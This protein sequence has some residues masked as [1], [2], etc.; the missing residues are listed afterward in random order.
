[1][2]SLEKIKDLDDLAREL[3]TLRDSKRIV[4]CHGVFDLLHIGHIRYF[5]QARKMGDVLVVTVTPDRYVNKGPHRPAFTETLRVE[6]I[7]ALDVVDYVTVNRWATAVEAIELLRPH[8]YV[9]GSEYRDAADDISGKIVDEAN[10]IRAVGGEMAFSDDL[11]FSS[12]S[13]INA[14]FPTVASEVVDFIADFNERHSAASILKYLDGARDL[15]VLV[16]GEAIIDEYQY[17]STIGKSGKEPILAAKYSSTETSIGGSLAIANHLASFCDNVTLLTFLGE[18]D[19]Q[20]AFINDRLHADVDRIF[21][22]LARCPTIVKRRFVESYPL[23]KLFE[24]YI[25]GDADEDAEFTAALCRKLEE[26]LADYDLVIVADYGHGMI[27][28][29]AARILCARSRYLAV[30]TQI[31]ADNHGFNTVSKYG[32]ADFVCISENELR[33]EFRSRTRTLEDITEELAKKLS[34]ERIVITRG[35]VGCVCFHCDQGFQVVPAFT[36][37]I[38]DRVGAGDAVFA[39]TSL[40]AN[41]EAPIEIIGCIG[42]AVGAQAVHTVANQSAVDRVALYKHIESLVK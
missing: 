14:H 32:R 2:T 27:G 23:Q 9:K 7:A 13:L 19:S 16:V 28:E 35:R 39:V 18:F 10:A 20:E 33:M 41:Q 40:A 37:R 25:M 30:N 31:N 4:Q 34:C 38:V 3:E 8:V 11:T 1:M 36:Q 6:A 5:G 12:S 22:T 17:C 42:S 24:L 15:K 29:A 26:T 21:L